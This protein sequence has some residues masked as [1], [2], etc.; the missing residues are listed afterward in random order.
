M[1]TVFLKAYRFNVCTSEFRKSQDF[2][3]VGATGG[4]EPSDV[5]DEHQTWS[6]TQSIKINNGGI[7]SSSPGWSAIFIIGN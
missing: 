2:S 7:N 3:G 1:P 5:D 4:C 6:P